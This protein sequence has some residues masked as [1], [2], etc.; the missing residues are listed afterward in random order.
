MD[1]DRFWNGSAGWT[2]VNSIWK[3]SDAEVSSAI[4]YLDPDLQDDSKT[5][6][7]SNPR[8]RRRVKVAFVI[9][10][11]AAIVYIAVLEYLP[12]VGRLLS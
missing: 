5:G 6:W 9:V 2:Q 10:T 7:R 11:I 4:R 12:A 8:L 3:V 1:R